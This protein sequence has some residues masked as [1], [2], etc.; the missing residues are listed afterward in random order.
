MMDWFP[1]LKRWSKWLLTSSSPGFLESRAACHLLTIYF[2]G[3]RLF[4]SGFLP[5]EAK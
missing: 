1:T 5:K 3:S 2:R 4:V